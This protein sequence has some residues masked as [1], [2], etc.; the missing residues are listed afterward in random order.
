M[1][2]E[3]LPRNAI[4]SPGGGAMGE[5]RLLAHDPQPIRGFS[6]CLSRVVLISLYAIFGRVHLI[7]RDAI[8]G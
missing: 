5:Y 7:K 8:I 4:F 6:G 1:I 3:L 2:Q